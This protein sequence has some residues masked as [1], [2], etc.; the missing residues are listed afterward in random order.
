MTSFT[1]E[2]RLAAESTEKIKKDRVTVM[3]LNLIDDCHRTAARVDPE[4]AI[5]LKLVASRI[6]EI[7]NTHYLK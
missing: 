4:T 5:Q 6:A 7:G 1:T 3:F 2:D